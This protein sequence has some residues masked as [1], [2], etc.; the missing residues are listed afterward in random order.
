VKFD[1]G[2][3]SLADEEEEVKYLIM[4]DLLSDHANIV[5]TYVTDN[6][7]NLAVARGDPLVREEDELKEKKGQ[8]R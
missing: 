1:A 3:A 4:F 7:E 6:K 2:L 5:E 8:G